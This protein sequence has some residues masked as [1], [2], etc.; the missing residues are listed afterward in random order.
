MFPVRKYFLGAILALIPFSGMAQ[1]VAKTL[2]VYDPV[3]VNGDLFQ[4][5][6]KFQLEA[7]GLGVK[8][9]LKPYTNEKTAAADFQASQCNAVLVTGTR[10]RPFHKFA[11]TLEAMG[12]LPK[13][14]HLNTAIK[15][16]SR[17]GAG[18]LM[19]SGEF[20]S[21]GVFPG[22]AIYLYVNDKNINTVEKLAGKR[23]ATLAFDE[24]AKTM[25]LI[26]LSF[27]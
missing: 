12:A 27:T 3:G 16:L 26:F 25:V 21:A 15:A 2:C 24:A 22:G 6:K 23:L 1:P 13:Y 14:A 10:A 11:G 8:F 19:K 9:E 20:E 4:M 5:M 17:A 18:K 7:L